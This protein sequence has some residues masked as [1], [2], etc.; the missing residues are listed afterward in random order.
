MPFVNPNNTTVG[1]EGSM[2]YLQDA[3]ITNS[4]TSTLGSNMVALAL[5]LPLWFIIFI[6]LAR[7]NVMGAITVSSFICW[8]A[9]IF[10]VAV[11]FLNPMG[12]SILLSMWIVGAVAYYLSTR[13]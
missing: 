9:S 4:T 5:L 11:G 6:P 3:L 12:S 10:L 7:T 8:F 1:I 2:Q 13:S